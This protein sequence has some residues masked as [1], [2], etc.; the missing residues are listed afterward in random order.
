MRT[1]FAFVCL[2]LCSCGTAPAPVISPTTPIAPVTPPIPSPAAKPSGKYQC[3]AQFSPGVTVTYMAT[4]HSDGSC[5]AEASLTLGSATY[6]ASESYSGD[7]GASD[8]AS[9]AVWLGSPQNGSPSSANIYPTGQRDGAQ[10]VVG[11]DPTSLVLSISGDGVPTQ[12]TA[13]GCSLIPN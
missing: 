9:C 11:S 6:V 12:G 7:D 8:A 4:Y 5:D 13:N 3:S 10:F 1:Y 2:A